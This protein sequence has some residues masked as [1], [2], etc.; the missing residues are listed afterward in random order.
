MTKAELFKK[1]GVRDEKEFYERYP[2]EDTF[3]K[4]H[5]DIPKMFLGGLLKTVLPTALSFIPGV[6]GAASGILSSVLNGGLKKGSGQGADLIGQGV[7]MAGNLLKGLFSKKNKTGMA[8]IAMG[9]AGAA[10]MLQNAQMDAQAR[11][12]F[13]DK[14][15]LQ[16]RALMDQF[17]D[18]DNP[19]LLRMGGDVENPSEIRHYK[20]AGTVEDA[21]IRPQFMRKSGK[22][23]AEVEAQEVVEDQ[24]GN[25]EYVNPNDPH[26][27]D[28]EQGGAL[29]S[30]AR[31]VLEATSAKPGRNDWKDKMLRL[32]PEEVE[33]GTGFKSKRSTSHAG[34]LMQADEYYGKQRAKYA[35]AIDKAND[36][37]RPD[38]IAMNTA[39]LNFKVAKT[40]P[41][42]DDLFEKL[43]AHQEGV[44]AKYGI[45]GGEEMQY[46]GIKYA[47]NG[48][49]IPPK[50]WNEMRRLRNTL[51]PQA[52][53]LPIE[54]DG[55]PAR[56]TS[57][58]FYDPI[59]ERTRTLLG[60]GTPTV[61]PMTIKP[62][63]KDMKSKRRQDALTDKTGWRGNLG[64]GNGYELEA[65]WREPNNRKGTSSTSGKKQTDED[66]SSGRKWQMATLD[67]L[68][69]TEGVDNKEMR[70]LRNERA[71]KVPSKISTSA[72]AVTPSAKAKSPASNGYRDEPLTAGDYRPL[73]QA[74]TLRKAPVRFSDVE[75]DTM[76][77]KRVSAAPELENNE[78]G[79]RMALRQVGDDASA[80]AQLQANKYRADN[81]VMGQNNNVNTQISNQETIGNTEIRNKEALF[82]AE[83]LNQF[84]AKV[85]QRDANFNTV[86]NDLLNQFQK[87]V[88]INK[89]FNRNAKRM[90][91]FAGKGLYDQDG[92]YIGPDNLFANREPIAADGTGNKVV[93]ETDVKWGI[94]P[95]DGK[96]RAQGTVSTTSKKKHGGKIKFKIK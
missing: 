2:D 74:L 51:E 23:N 60:D 72:P 42:A 14:I 21:D 80:I 71:L 16:S 13:L 45:D 69:M 65:P 24:E 58:K 82:K 57:K 77:L 10:T 20:Y 9:G 17:G 30:D 1:V 92:N 94:T 25:I 37:K 52:R 39:Q 78:S 22:I 5:P 12:T 11:E 54:D 62:G 79:Y 88:Q 49:E 84:D 43:F 36:M 70:N 83:N 56:G 28:H 46:G 68:D 44:K 96:V 75:M 90:T 38:K 87:N 35:K 93:R 91:Q 55:I 8:P 89:A 76:K 86:K 41:I 61:K 85:Q 34:A 95:I 59:G 19:L 73:V 53:P 50:D 29:M 6:G 26:A 63:A 40:L 3:N 67:D 33:F 66:Q 47:Q 27:N 81:Q 4:A 32:S 64:T 7:G 15:Q 31:R 48:I 18:D